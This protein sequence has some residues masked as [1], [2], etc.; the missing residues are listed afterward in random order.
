M[1]LRHT[2]RKKD[3]KTHRYWRLV[4]SERH[5][6]RVVQRTMAH[7]GALDAQGQVQAHALARSLIGAPEQA[8]LFDDGKPDITIPVRL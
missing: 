3:G 1:Y 4:R 7:L 2:I 8:G 6:R 5:G